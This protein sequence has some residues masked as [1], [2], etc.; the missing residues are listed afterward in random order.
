MPALPRR[1]MN[2]TVFL[3]RTEAEARSGSP[4]GA[5]GFIVGLRPLREELK[6]NGHPTAWHLYAVTAGHVIAQDARVMRWTIWPAGIHS[7][8]ITTGDVFTPPWIS[9][10]VADLAIA[11]LGMTVSP[12]IHYRLLPFIDSAWLAADQNIAANFGG[13]LT[14]GDEVFMVGRFSGVTDGPK[15]NP[16]ARF[17]HIATLPLEIPHA[18]FYRHP[19]Y[20][21]E[22]RSINQ[23]SGSPVFSYVPK[24]EHLKETDREEAAKNITPAEAVD[25]V[26]RNVLVLGV[27][28]GH[29]REVIEGTADDP[30]EGRTFKVKFPMNSVMA[31]VTP[32]DYIM[33]MFNMPDLLKHR[34]E[35]EDVLAKSFAE[36]NVELDFDAGS[37]DDPPMTRDAF[38]DALRRASR[39]TGENSEA[40]RTEG[41]SE[42]SE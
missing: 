24:T 28:T 26:K 37:E 39:P 31:V 33:E 8:T 23:F 14:V 22:M 3:Y 12:P 25:A 30:K 18:P 41:N 29:L 2:A 21:V 1:V 35:S 4:T 42:T 13:Q 34:E 38:F 27:D 17:G 15:N 20:L 5:S 40:P 16:V 10:E 19:S 9:H 11:P 7:P 6:I 32:A 36:S